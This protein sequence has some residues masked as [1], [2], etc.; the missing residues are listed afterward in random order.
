MKKTE[1]GQRA[2]MKINLPAVIA[3][4]AVMLITVVTV[5]GMELGGFDVDVGIG[6]GEDWVEEIPWENEPQEIPDEH[7]D[8]NE[9]REEWGDFIAEE[10]HTV[11]PEETLA[12]EQWN[13]PDDEDCGEGVEPT[14]T[15]TPIITVEPTVIAAPIITVSSTRIPSPTPVITLTSVPTPT[16]IPFAYYRECAEENR[17]QQDYPV[18]FRH[19]KGG[20]PGQCPEIEIRSKGTVQVFS[21]RL[22]GEES[23][24]HWNGDTI[25]MD[26][27]AEKGENIIELLVFS[28]GGR[29][30]RMKP[31]VFTS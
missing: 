3:S 18:G 29:L 27:K 11:Q 12:E 16:R 15:A 8:S 26:K 20:E 4:I 17:K 6:E 19:K 24:W 5:R 28:Q 10:D 21:L 2:F 13:A 25:I 9:S 31:W 23:P 22:N 30:V 7:E 14:V 1:R